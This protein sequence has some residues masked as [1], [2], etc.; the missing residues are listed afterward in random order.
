MRVDRRSLSLRTFLQGSLTPRRRDNRRGSE[1]EGLLDWHEP[2]LM[3][4]AVIILMLSVTDAFL[5]LKLIG[6]GAHEANPIMNHL[7]MQTPTLFATIKM[8]LTGG[9][10][11]V[12]VALARAR[13][14]RIIRISK[15]IY[16]C[17]IGYVALITYEAWLLSLIP[18]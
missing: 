15:I 9:G 12:L 16:W 10:I 7:L 18:A 14:F 6:K 1:F 8:A 17:L 2:H 4:L 3:Y 5:T 13:I 11:V